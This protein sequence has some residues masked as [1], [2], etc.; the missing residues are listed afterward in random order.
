MNYNQAYGSIED[1]P[2]VPSCP[3]TIVREMVEKRKNQNTQL[4]YPFL[5]TC[6]YKDQRV[7]YL[8]SN[9]MK[10]GMVTLRDDKVRKSLV[11]RDRIESIAGQPLGSHLTSDDIPDSS[12]GGDARWTLDSLGARVEEL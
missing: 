6:I 3:A 7:P 11:A 8:P 9:Q 5:I 1:L 4:V 10:K 2:I 12:R